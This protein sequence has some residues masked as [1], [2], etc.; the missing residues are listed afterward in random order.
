MTVRIRSRKLTGAVT[1]LP[2]ITRTFLEVPRVP[3]VLQE[4]TP[5]ITDNRYAQIVPQVCLRRLQDSHPLILVVA[6]QGIMD[7]S[8]D[9]V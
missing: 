7:L 6:L 2:D 8:V 3:L 1:V 5:K 4:N 9:H